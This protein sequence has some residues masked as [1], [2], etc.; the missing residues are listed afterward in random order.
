MKQKNAEQVLLHPVYKFLIPSQRRPKKVDPVHHR[1]KIFSYKLPPTLTCTNESS[2]PAQHSI[3][4]RSKARCTCKVYQ[5]AWRAIC[6][7]RPSLLRVTRDD[8]PAPDFPSPQQHCS[9]LTVRVL[10]SRFFARTRFRERRSA[11][12]LRITHSISDSRS[13]LS[14]LFPFLRFFLSFFL[15]T[16]GKFLK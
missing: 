16:R 14:S 10:V 11:F 1:K 8:D 9:S 3:T 5:R 13:R 15:S 12:L 6:K 2:Q 4:N 7:R